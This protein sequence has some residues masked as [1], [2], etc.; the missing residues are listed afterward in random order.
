MRTY[1][2]LYTTT[3]TTSCGGAEV[4]EHALGAVVRRL[5]AVAGLFGAQDGRDPVQ[6]VHC[7]EGLLRI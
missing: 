3:T 1:S 4:I 2:R 5:V 7:I 6:V